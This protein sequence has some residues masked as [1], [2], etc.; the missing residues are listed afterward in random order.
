MKGVEPLQEASSMVA[1]LCE[2]VDGL[3]FKQRR[4]KEDARHYKRMKE[5]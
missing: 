1:G 5:M 2:A 3:L 4:L